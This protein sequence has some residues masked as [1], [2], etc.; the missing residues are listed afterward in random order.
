MRKIKSSR[1]LQGLIALCVIAALSGLWLLRATPLVHDIVM[2]LWGQY[3]RYLVPVVIVMIAAAPFGVKY[4]RWHRLTRNERDEREEALR[5]W[6]GGFGPHPGSLI[7]TRHYYVSVLQGSLMVGAAVLASA[8]IVVF[9]VM[10]GAAVGQRIALDNE[11]ADIAAL[12]GM[13]SVRTMPLDVMDNM[14]SNGFSRTT[15]ELENGHMVVAGRRLLMT[16]EVAPSGFFR[17]HSKATSGLATQD[18]TVSERTLRTIDPSGGFSTAPSTKGWFFQP[19]SWKRSLRVAAYR[20]HYLTKIQE[21]VGIATPD[22]E[23]LFLAPY[24][25][26]KGLLIRRP[27]L[28]GVFVA[29]ADGRVED[30]SIEEARKRPEIAVSGRLIPES[31]VRQIHSNIRYR[32]GLW[33]GKF[34]RKGV[35]VLSDSA[36]VGNAQPYLTVLQDG[37]AVWIS[38]AEP[39]GKSTSAGAVFVTDA[40]TAK[41]EIWTPTDDEFVTGPQKA[42]GKIKERPIAGIQ[43]GNGNYEAVEPRPLFIDG[44]LHYLISITNTEKTGL[45]KSVIFNAHRDQV[46]AVFNHDDESVNADAQLISYIESGESD[47]T[48]PAEPEEAPET[49]ASDHGSPS[50]PAAGD[51]HQLTSEQRQQLLRK[52]IEQNDEQRELL[53]QLVSQEQDNSR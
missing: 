36:A 9:M 26:Y 43:W 53:E 27:V 11:Y 15:E 29:H 44:Q 50:A 28:G 34:G 33:N 12:P 22:G 13:A 45:V 7:A 19:W 18:P 32:S 2:H 20:K 52:L 21:Y 5:A 10:Y 8:A 6:E 38:T 3:P 16:H 49:S 14:A 23:V 39:K 30:L 40:V 41:T 31:Y 47:L 46:V 1:R 17:R 4:L 37:R 25:M 35:Y 42:L 24:I 51:L 48:E